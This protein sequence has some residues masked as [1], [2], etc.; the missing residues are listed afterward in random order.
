MPAE[1]KSKPKRALLIMLAGV[2]GF[3]MACVLAFVL[4]AMRK[5]KEDPEGKARWDALRQAWK[6]K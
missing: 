4:E 6:A 5:S 3:F 1:K 2:G